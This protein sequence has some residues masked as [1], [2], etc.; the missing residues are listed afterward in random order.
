MEPNLILEYDPADIVDENDA[1]NAYETMAVEVGTFHPDDSGH[2]ILNED[3]TGL[4]F[5]PEQADRYDAVMAAIRPLIGDAIYDLALA[6]TE[7]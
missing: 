5:T 7:D 1:R 4:Y 6:Y 3:G 2:E